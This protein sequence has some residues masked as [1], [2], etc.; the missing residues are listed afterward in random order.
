MLGRFGALTIVPFL[1][2]LYETEDNIKKT[3]IILHGFQVAMEYGADGRDVAQ[4]LV[5][6]FFGAKDPLVRKI[7]IGIFGERCDKSLVPFFREIC[8]KESGGGVG[9][10][11]IE[12]MRTRWGRGVIPILKRF[13]GP[14][15]DFHIYKG[16]LKMIIEDP[17]KS[18][19]PILT[20]IYASEE[21]PA[22]RSWIV[23]SFASREGVGVTSLLKKAY[24]SEED[25]TVRGDILW[26]MRKHSDEIGKNFFKKVSGKEKSTEFWER[27]IKLEFEPWDID[28]ADL[29]I[30]ICKKRILS[31]RELGRI[32][33]RDEF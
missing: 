27:I 20:E 3:C 2:G 32:F 10:R 1:K 30:E 28:G 15:E 4:F 31:V 7:I 23:D 5:T 24:S 26:A 19:I 6:S 12:A 18:A 8:V 33:E 13:C 11:D 21:R 22:Y 14:Q 16:F 25:S 9:G 17:D 29:I